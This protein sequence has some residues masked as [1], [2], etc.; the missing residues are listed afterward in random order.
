V[1]LFAYFNPE[2]GTKLIIPFAGIEWDLGIWYIPFTVV[3]VVLIV[4]S[5]N[6]TDGLDGLASGVTIINAATYTIIF[7]GMLQQLSGYT[8][9]R[10]I[11]V[12]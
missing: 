7:Y 8:A 5:V 12:I 4:N 2:I 3:A 10:L 9:R 1:A 6:L 11:P